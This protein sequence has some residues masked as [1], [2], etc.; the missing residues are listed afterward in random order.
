MAILVACGRVKGPIPIQAL[1]YPLNAS[2]PIMVI[3]PKKMGVLGEYS[4]DSGN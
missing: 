2:Q 3:S 4:E 1:F